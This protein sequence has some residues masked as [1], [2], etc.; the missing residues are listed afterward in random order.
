MA[1]KTTTGFPDFGEPG[2]E[3]KRLRV[4]PLKQKQ[5]SQILES[6]GSEVKRSRG[7][8]SKQQQDSEILE[9]QELR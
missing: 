3:V 4:Q 5:D 2:I 6:L 9:S 7:R 1:I 8:P